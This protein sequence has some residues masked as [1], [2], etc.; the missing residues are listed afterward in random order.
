[1]GHEDLCSGDDTY[2]EEEE[3]CYH[4]LAVIDSG[5]LSEAQINAL[6]ARIQ[7]KG[8]CYNCGR[9]GHIAKHCRLARRSFQG[10]CNFY[11]GRLNTGPTTIG[12]QPHTNG[13]VGTFPEE[14]VELPT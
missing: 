14:E 5:V 10:R 1:M 8:R 7:R 4:T 6:R 11:R 9:A 12:G 3:E 13:V 2:I